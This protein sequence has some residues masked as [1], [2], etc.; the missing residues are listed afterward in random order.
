MPEPPVVVIESTSTWTL[1]DWQECLEYR[2]LLYFLVLRD[3]TVLY[4][5][6]VLGIAWA[7]LTPFFSMVR[8]V[9]RKETLPSGVRNLVSSEMSELLS[10]A[11]ACLIT[12][13]FMAV[14]PMWTVILVKGNYL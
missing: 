13:S 14:T 6:T 4:K 10:T 7:V 9:L 1:F 2:D 12:M 11:A 5:Q 8:A 3:V